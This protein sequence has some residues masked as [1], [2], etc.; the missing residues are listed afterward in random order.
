MNMISNTQ[1]VVASVVLVLYFLL[2]GGEAVAMMVLFSWIL[3]MRKAQSGRR[4]SAKTQSVAYL[5][6]QSRNEF[7]KAFSG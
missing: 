6:H 7:R 4:V 2:F 3:L 5:P 1:F